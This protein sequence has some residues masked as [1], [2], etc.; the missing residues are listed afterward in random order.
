MSSSFRYSAP[1][2]NC[3]ARVYVSMCA[4]MLD[5]DGSLFACE[6]IKSPSEKP[7]DILFDAIKC[8]ERVEEAEIH[9]CIFI[10]SLEPPLTFNI[11]WASVNI[12]HI[13]VY[14]ERSN[15]HFYLSMA[16]KVKPT[17]K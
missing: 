1:P 9:L 15:E 5:V 8:C 16:H 11:E 2:F 10:A 14:V 6:H 13:A 3:I 7:L 17:I 4:S 12:R